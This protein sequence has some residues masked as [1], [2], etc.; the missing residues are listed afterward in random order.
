MKKK[1]E[2]RGRPSTKHKPVM[3]GFGK[4]LEALADSTY[5]EEKKLKDKKKK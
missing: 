5:K 1:G 3:G 4:V 2:T